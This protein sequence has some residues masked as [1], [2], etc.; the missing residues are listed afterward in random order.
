MLTALSFCHKDH[1]LALKQ[2]KW[3]NR[4]GGASSHP[5]CVVFNHMAKEYSEPIIKELKEAFLMMDVLI[6]SDNVE[7]KWPFAPNH[8]FQRFNKDYI[9]NREE[10]YLWME[11]DAIPL[12]K[13]WLNTIELEF[14]ACRKPFMGDYV[15]VVVDGKQVPEHMSGVA[16][17]RQIDF[18]APS[19]ITA[20]N[21]AWDVVA[22]RDILPK[23]H[24]TKLIQHEWR[25]ETFKD[26]AALS[27]I[28]KGAVI[29]H[30]NKDGSL[31]DI[32]SDGAIEVS[33]TI[34]ANQESWVKASS[35]IGK[36]APPSITEQ[37][38]SLCF[39]LNDLVKDKPGRKVLML[40]ELRSLKIIPQ[41]RKK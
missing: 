35:E 29:Y 33:Q 15:N 7:Q 11:P 21:I 18:N 23:F 31:I 3:I 13:E 34:D 4:L 19:Y 30:Q 22:A 6:V 24:A 38:K 32:L 27:R 8:M 9:Q 26:K 25:P 41:A 5:C 12:T 28:R 20:S 16:V 14:K 37:I 17:Y 1:E 36:A 10:P 40:D 39:Q 2:A